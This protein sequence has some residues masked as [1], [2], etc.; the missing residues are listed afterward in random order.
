D[1]MIRSRQA[2]LNKGYY[3]IVSDTIVQQI[4]SMPQISKESI[5]DVGCGEGY[6]MQGVV[7]TLAH[8]KLSLCGIDI[9][10]SA[11]K[12]AGKRKL[13][14]ILC[15]ASAYDLPFF[16]ESFSTIISVFSPISTLEIE[17][18]LKADGKIIMVGPGEEHLKGLTAHIYDEVL[19]HKGNYSVVDESKNLTFIEQIEIKKEIV[20][21]QEDILD[22]LRMTPYYWQITVKKKE[23]ILALSE[24]RTIIHFYM[25]IYS[26]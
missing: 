10:K 8:E 17:R 7:D 24:L 3:K 12:L 2:F 22:L 4:D 19:P 16:D 5:L 21:K 9:S 23:K 6:Y 18:L 20:V 26:K 1:E 13:G 14:A 11:V 25:R 15:V